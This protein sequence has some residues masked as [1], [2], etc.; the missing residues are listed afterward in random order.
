MAY[1]GT[2]FKKRRDEIASDYNGTLKAML[3]NIV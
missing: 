3:I 1:N 2:R